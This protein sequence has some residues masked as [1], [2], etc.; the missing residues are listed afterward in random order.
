MSDRP[1]LGTEGG[2]EGGV[3]GRPW[4]GTEGGMEGG[5]S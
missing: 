4:L 1:W 3:N 2:M 5:G